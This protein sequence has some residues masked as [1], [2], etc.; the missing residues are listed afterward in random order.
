M[1]ASSGNEQDDLVQ[2]AYIYLVEH[3]YPPNCSQQRKR[4]IRRKAEKFEVRDGEL[5]IMKQKKQARSGNKVI[6]M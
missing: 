1:D 2:E 3:R 5:F 4:T 6:F